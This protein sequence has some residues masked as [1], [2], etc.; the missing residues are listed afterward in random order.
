MLY[1]IG[2]GLND[3]GDVPVKAI[4]AL[5]RCDEVYAELYTSAWKGDLGELEKET[6]KR[7]Q[8]LQ[9]EHVE[10]NSL[11]ER[12]ADR[13]V[14]LLVPGDPLTATTHI[15]LLARARRAK[16]EV[17]V[18]HASS[19]YTAIAESGLQLYKF[20]RTTTI[21]RPEPGFEPT[22]PYEI[23]AEN[24]KAGLHT[25]VLLDIPMKIGE[26]LEQLLKLEGQL[27]LGLITKSTKIVACVALGDEHQLIKYET[28]EK[29]L[30]SGIEQ[31]PACIIVPGKLH[32]SEEEVLELWKVQ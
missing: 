26:S 15:D 3:E 11:I 21:P 17:K 27:R 2:L 22:S 31:T 7:I 12:A 16:I 23:I 24:K 4:A 25:L 1:L 29:L 9:R 30:K 10:S 5:Q 14:A 20:G 13:S 28:I 32:F 8:V 18:I 19:I 6:G